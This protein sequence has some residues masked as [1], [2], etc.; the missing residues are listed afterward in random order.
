MRNSV[1]LSSRTRCVRQKSNLAAAVVQIRATQ[2]GIRDL[3]LFLAAK[4]PTL[5]LHDALVTLEDLD[6]DGDA[7]M[8]ADPAFM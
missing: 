1:V 8:I 2:Y 7:K 3:H 4:P 6:T 5:T